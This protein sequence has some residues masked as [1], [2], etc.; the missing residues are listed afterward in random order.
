VI[1][2]AALVLSIKLGAL[3]DRLRLPEPQATCGIETTS[4]LFKGEPGTEFRY[5][6]ETYRLPVTGA[7]ELIATRSNS[8]EVAGR[9][10]G[11]DVAA[12]DEFGRRTVQVPALVPPVL[13]ASNQSQET[14]AGALPT[15]RRKH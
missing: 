1:T 14:A 3:L 4:Y 15:V 10:L 8:Y 9:R 12:A 2:I 7:L 11:L 5:A 13:A 6:G